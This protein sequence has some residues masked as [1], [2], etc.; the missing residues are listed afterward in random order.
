MQKAI[1]KLHIAKVTL[2]NRTVVDYLYHLKLT[3]HLSLVLSKKIFSLPNLL[4]IAMT[5]VLA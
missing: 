2:I 5:S 3:K 1:L 4:F